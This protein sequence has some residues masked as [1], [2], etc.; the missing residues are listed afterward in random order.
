MP[1]LLYQF[2]AT[3][4]KALGIIPARFASTRFPGKPLVDI[5]GM[6]MVERVY[7]QANA[8]Q[9]THVVVATDDAR[10][11]HHV[12]AFGGQA[13]LTSDRHQSGTDRCY[14]ALQ[15]LQQEYEVVVNIQGDEPFIQ[16]EQID[17]VLSCFQRPDAQIATLIK[18]VKDQQEL[19]N[20]NS[21][22][23]V[24][25]AEGQALYFSRHPIPYLRGVEQG[26]WLESHTFYKHIGIYGY[27]TEVLAQLT[28]L[29]PS[30]LEKAESLEQLRWLEHGLR[31]TTA[32]TAVET[33]GIDTPEDLDKANAY[34]LS[35]GL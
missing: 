18:P 6:S 20:A 27:Q 12:Q 3:R 24:I 32:V 17:K 34:L 14:E 2:A 1:S 30:A 28:Q 29:T 35:L 31:I 11:V 4:M 15:V 23:V 22:K 7:A 21:P 9:L 26:K 25:G 33:I 5:G 13:V 10:I 16:P 19:F 8:A